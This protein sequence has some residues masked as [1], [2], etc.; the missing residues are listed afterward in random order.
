MNLQTE[1][2]HALL[3]L[4]SLSHEV[5]RKRALRFLLLLS[6]TAVIGFGFL[7]YL[8]DPNIPSVWTGMWYALTTMTH[9][10]FGDVVPA[11]FLGKLLSS[12]L[13][14]LGVGFFAVA[15]ALFAAVLVSHEMRGIE[16]EVEAV[17]RDMTDMESAETH[18]ILQ[19]QAIERR[20]TAIQTSLKESGQPGRISRQRKSDKT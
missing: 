12:L 4:R 11:S 16:R 18:I 19:L 14:L 10:G 5:S 9:V 2:R 8:I 15:T 20:L 6:G 7:F 17:E 3:W 1:M 13:I